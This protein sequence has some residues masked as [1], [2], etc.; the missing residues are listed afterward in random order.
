MKQYPTP[1]MSLQAVEKLMERGALTL[2]RK[3][4]EALLRRYIDLQRQTRRLRVAEWEVARALVPDWHGT[5]E[6]LIQT[7]KELA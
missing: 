6:Q 4:K 5:P 2:D 1:Q 3:G 7:A